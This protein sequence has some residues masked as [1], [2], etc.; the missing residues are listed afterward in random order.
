M[1]ARSSLYRAT[2]YGTCTFRQPS[3]KSVE[4]TKRTCARP[5]LTLP[6][7]S[8][9]STSGKLRIKY[10]LKNTQD[11]HIT[12]T[13]ATNHI[14]VGPTNEHIQLPEHRIRDLLHSGII[15]VDHGEVEPSVSEVSWPEDISAASAS[16]TEQEPEQRVLITRRA[17][18]RSPMR[19]SRLASLGMVIAD[20]R[21]T[22]I[23]RSTS[24]AQ[25]SEA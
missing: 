10:H 16:V 5:N 9:S 20:L 7:S 17:T 24:T 8:P 23:Q 13:S 1:R 14:Q 15:P 2:K 11:H 25:P 19:A 4:E 21:A 18:A 22:R 12:T 3:S 6:V